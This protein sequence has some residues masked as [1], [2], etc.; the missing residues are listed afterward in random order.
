MVT[1]LARLKAEAVAEKHPDALV[2][3]SDQSA[4]LDGE[5]LTK[6]GNFD[7]A[8]KPE[9]AVLGNKFRVATQLNRLVQIAS[10]RDGRDQA[11]H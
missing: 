7:N 2:I 6:S 3:G 4:V 9:V 11:P 8:V 1:R 5:I 10:R